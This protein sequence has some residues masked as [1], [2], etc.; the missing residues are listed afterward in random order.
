V[1]YGS[2]WTK[3]IYRKFKN[4]GEGVVLDVLIRYL[5]KVNENEHMKIKFTCTGL[6]GSVESNCTLQP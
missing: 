3:A 1:K 5:T 2:T 6:V 4:M